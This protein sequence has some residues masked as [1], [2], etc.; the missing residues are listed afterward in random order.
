[1]LQLEGM[2]TFSE[3]KVKDQLAAIEKLQVRQAALLQH[4]WQRSTS[5]QAALYSHRQMQHLTS[6]GSNGRFDMLKAQRQQYRNETQAYKAQQRDVSSASCCL[7]LKSFCACV[8]AAAGPG[9]QLK[10]RAAGGSWSSNADARPLQDSSTGA[11]S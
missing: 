9:G 1:L 10:Q 3:R 6:I 11:A 2:L 7:V 5:S 8:C 4:L